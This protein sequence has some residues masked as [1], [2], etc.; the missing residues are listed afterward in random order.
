MTTDRSF[1]N[2]VR[3]RMSKTGESYTTARR[4]LLAKSTASAPPSAGDG[5][6]ALA[7]SEASVRERTG[8]G[9]DEWFA[10]LDAWGAADRRHPAIA[11]WLMAEHR[12]DNWWSQS[13]TV[14]YEQERGLRVPGQT[15]DG[16]FSATGSRTIAA[17]VERLFE[18]FADAGLRERW[19]PGAKLTV[20]TATA[21]KSLRADWGDDGTRVAVGF[22][23]KGDGR[24]QVAVGHER[25]PDAEAAARMKG[26]WRDR[27]A[28][29]KDLLEA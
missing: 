22:V 18:A 2:R 4:Q 16:Y 21:P 23:A 3:A 28:D 10:L 5:V 24:A 20:R 17:P 29:L 13:I 1:K 9:W 27:L 7:H 15:S 14:R 26:F 8:R 25:L 6:R 12:V 19:L 11:K